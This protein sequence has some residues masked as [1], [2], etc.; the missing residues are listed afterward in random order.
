MNKS[1]N[2]AESR[3]TFTCRLSERLY[4]SIKV[5]AA[6]EGI[7]TGELVIAA[8]EQYLANR[9]EEGRDDDRDQGTYEHFLSRPVDP[10]PPPI[11]PERHRFKSRRLVPVAIKEPDAEH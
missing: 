9:R 2:S 8:L 11:F 7:K 10:P 6:R 5:K 3:R 4:R 1:R